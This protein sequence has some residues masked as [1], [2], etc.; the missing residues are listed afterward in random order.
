MLRFANTLLLSSFVFASCSL[1]AQDLPQPYASIHTVHLVPS[2]FDNRFQVLDRL[3]ATSAKIFIDV[4]SHEGSAARMVAQYTTDIQIYNVCIWQSCDLSIKYQYQKFL[5][6]VI[7]EKAANRITP[8]RMTSQDGAKA[9][10]VIADVIYLNGIDTSLSTEILA[11]SAHLTPTGS[12]CGHNWMEST[13]QNAVI[14]AANKLD[15]A[16]HV[17][18]DFWYLDR[19]N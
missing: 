7:L 2:Y 13:V 9:L 3:K 1:S 17:D 5:S 11:W 16:V 4:G 14:S 19:G 6:N 18:G 15:L 12:I 8:I 10:N